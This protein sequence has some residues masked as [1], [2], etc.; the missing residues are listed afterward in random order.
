M[1]KPDRTRY[2]IALAATAISLTGGIG[3]GLLIDS[4]RAGAPIAGLV[5]GAATIAISVLLW[6]FGQQAARHDPAVTAPE[7]RLAEAEQTRKRLQEEL[8]AQQSIAAQLG[9]QIEALS[10]PVIPIRQGIVVVPLIGALDI[11][12]LERMGQSLLHGIEQ[13][14]ARVA[15]IDLTGVTGLALNAVPQLARVISSVELMGCQTVLTGLNT[16]TVRALLAQ[17]LDLHAQARLNLEAGIA[18]AS[19]LVLGQTELDR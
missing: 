12:Q 9:A 14:S 5:I 13:Q 1:N 4:G 16:D 6:H 8:A 19:N 3:I 15:I 10:A 7:T 17:K 2:T 11:A 18:Y